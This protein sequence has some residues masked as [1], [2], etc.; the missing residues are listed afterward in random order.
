MRP[1]PI[2][3]LFL[4]ACSTPATQPAPDAP[5]PAQSFQ[6]LPLQYAS[7]DELASTLNGLFARNPDVRVM[8]DRRTNSLLVMAGPDEMPHIEALVHRLDVEVKPAK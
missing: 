1:I 2:L 4:A 5:K 7:G 3:L 8:V 6:V